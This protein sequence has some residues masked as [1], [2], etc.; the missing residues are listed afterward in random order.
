MLNENLQVKPIFKGNWM[1]RFLK[2]SLESYSIQLTLALCISGVHMC[3]NNV[4]GL[5]Y[6]ILLLV[7]VSF[8]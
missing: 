2:I 6:S 8:F 4:E 7:N 3:T 1:L 5:I